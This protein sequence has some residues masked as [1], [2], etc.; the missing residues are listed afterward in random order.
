MVYHLGQ[1]PVYFK[2][3]THY[4][5]TYT[6]YRNLLLTGPVVVATTVIVIFYF[7]VCV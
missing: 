3:F 1:Y 7:I 4:L 5:L 6:E 2:Y